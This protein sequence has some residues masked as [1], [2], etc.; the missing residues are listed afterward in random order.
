MKTLVAVILTLCS[1]GVLLAQTGADEAVDPR[2]LYQRGREEQARSNLPAAVELYRG[3][4]R[5]NP[6][7]D[8]PLIGLAETFF[9]LEEYEEALEYLKEAQKYDQGNLD[10]IVL[11]GRLS[12][13]LNQPTRAR[14]LFE[15]V[16]EKEK[17]NL[18]ARFGLAELDIA[19]GRTRNA[20]RRYIEALK[21]R[22]DS[23]KALLS[24]VLLSDARGDRDAAEAYLE[25]ALKYHSYDPRVHYAAGRFSIEEGRF[26]RA[27]NYLLTAIALDNEYM[28]AK[29]L[30]AQVY[31]LRDEPNEAI[32]IL[33][34]ILET[35]RTSPLVWYSLG[36]AYDRSGDPEQGIRALAQALRRSPDDEIARIV[37]ENIALKENPIDDPIRAHYAAYHLERGNLFKERNLPAKALM[38]YR[39][40][41]RLQPESKEPRL[42]YAEL[43][44]LM[45]FPVKYMKELEVLRDLGYTDPIILDD[46]EIIAGSRYE[47]VEAAWGIDQYSLD[48]KRFSVALYHLLPATRELHPFAGRAAAEYLHDL[49][50][51]YPAL[52]LLDT[53]LNVDGVESAFRKARGLGSDYFLMLHIEESERSFTAVLE[54]YLTATGKLLQSYRVFRT[55]NDRV[56]DNLNILAERFFDALPLKG[57]LLARQFDRGVID[58]GKHDG[59]EP[60]QVLSIV[61]K[62][63]LRLENSRIGLTTNR[64]DI[65]GTFTVSAVDENISEGTVQKRSFF[66]LINSGDEIIALVPEPPPE[67]IEEG[68]P[69]LLRRLISVI[70][71]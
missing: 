50:Q 30:L 68:E 38:E 42:F 46:I 5:E 37:L 22:P 12:I 36:L 18:E 31:L 13:A 48:R 70:G 33:R 3:A 6:A 57:T 7:Y 49:L 2:V 23:Q 52:E 20:G 15:S 64:E 19:Q 54:M 45:G 43:Y 4:L 34:E 16:L 32:D 35:D 44:R 14:I 60:A 51:R 59:L 47:S 24:L 65:L 56:Q 63:R 66:D 8:R 21:I 29:R 9:A 61:K 71:R 25:L 69:G 67:Q 40:A 27:Q 53:A 17:N 55:G 10:L 39:R 62:G 26:D 11:E 41:L 1:A 28:E 58:L